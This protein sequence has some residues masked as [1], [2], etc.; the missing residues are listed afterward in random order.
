MSNTSSVHDLFRFVRLRAVGE[1]DAKVGDPHLSDS[2]LCG[3]LYRLPRE[4]RAK[5]ARQWLGEKGTRA[6]LS[7]ELFLNLLAVVRDVA[8]RSAPVT[9]DTLLRCL[10]EQGLFAAGRCDALRSLAAQL[11]DLLLALLYAP[12]STTTPIADIEEVYRTLLLL[13]AAFDAGIS[14]GAEHELVEQ[15]LL[16]VFSRPIEI[17]KALAASLDRLSAGVA[18]LLV[19]KQHIKCY[20]PGEIARIENVA[21]GETR[22]RAHRRLDRLEQT[23]E[24]EIERE[25]ES[26]NELETTE[27]FEVSKEANRTIKEDQQLSFGVNVSAAYGP[28]QF[29]S[30]FDFSRSDSRELSVKEATTYAKE[31]VERSLERIQERVRRT[32]K[33]R[34]MREVEEQNSH[35]YNNETAE[36][37][38][39]IYQ[40]VDKIFEAQVFNYGKREMLDLA[41]PDPASYLWHRRGLPS[42]DEPAIEVPLKPDPLPTNAIG[43]LEVETGGV[44]NYERWATQYR[45]TGI[46]APPE[47]RVTVSAT[48]EYPS[49]ETA[50]GI[51]VS[52]LDV[53]LPEKYKPTTARVSAIAWS[54]DDTVLDGGKSFFHQLLTIGVTVLDR[55]SI[56]NFER[57]HSMPAF[58]EHQLVKYLRPNFVHDAISGRTD[59]IA[60][61]GANGETEVQLDSGSVAAEGGLKLGIF[62]YNTTKY[63]VSVKIDCELTE[64][65][66]QAWRLATFDS[67]Q[68]AFNERMLEYQEARSRYEQELRLRQTEDNAEREFGETPSRKEEII[69]SELKKHCIA[70]IT[71]DFFA[72]N[73]VPPVMQFPAGKPPRFDLQRAHTRGAFVRF[74]E[75]AFEWEHIQYVFYPYFWTGQSNWDRR[76][77]EDDASHTFRQF[78]QAGWC[79]VVVPVRP[80]FERAFHYYLLTG[81]VW[82]GGELPRVGDELYV[83]IADEI[84][85]QTDG[86]VT[87][88]VPYGSPWQ[89]RVPTSLVYLRKEDTLPRWTRI[90]PGAEDSPPDHWRWETAPGGACS[91][92]REA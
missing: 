71:E 30:D 33:T 66:L 19:V 29:G 43:Q 6:A 9:I 2:N 21:S 38:H 26:E 63:V 92:P 81:N 88:A 15:D 34:I 89:V 23:F 87:T 79:R 14:A 74:F 51:S 44:A 77:D 24:T 35:G 56:Y 53:K 72:A 68:T 85:S 70:I 61:F 42:T 47:R 48:R 76:F 28:V 10:E 11:S 58:A 82:M 65:A 32:Q 12:R 17:P 41:I 80:G 60:L 64:E 20:E 36:H 40:F 27:R 8:E 69:R 16:E 22:E 54:P 52:L 4:E 90:E 18:D 31:I 25:V 3:E 78:M 75:Q 91:D 83:S 55:I 46:S 57:D 1:R 39:A 49:E 73:D 59:Q 84:R 50:E 37:R 67:I 7:D 5:R 62:A 13:I 45:A 86:D